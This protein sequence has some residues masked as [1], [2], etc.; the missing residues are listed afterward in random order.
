MKSVPYHIIGIDGRRCAGQQYWLGNV[1]FGSKAEVT[2][3][4]FDV[5]F[6]PENG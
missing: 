1:A 4:N 2:P 6:T 5:R 3:S